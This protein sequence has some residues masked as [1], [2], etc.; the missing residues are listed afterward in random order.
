MGTT[1]HPDGIRLMTLCSRY[2]IPNLVIVSGLLLTTL[3]CA[4]T[5]HSPCVASPQSI[6]ARLGNA[7]NATAFFDLVAGMTERQRDSAILSELQSGNIPDFLRNL[8]PVS[9]ISRASDGTALSLTLCVMA[10]Y[11]SIGSDTDF[12]RMPMELN[13]ALLVAEQFGF[14]LP[15]PQ[16]VDLIYGQAPLH[17]APQP[18][19]AGNDMRSSEYY[20]LHNVMVKLQREASGMGLEVLTAGHKKDLVLSTRLWNMPGRVAIYGWQRPSG[21]PIQPLSTVHGSHYAD[22]SHGVRL[23]SNTVYVNGAARSMDDVIGDPKLAPLLSTEGPLPS[24]TAWLARIVN[25]TDGS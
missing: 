5:V 23:V 15:T 4:R 20:R 11:L 16:M 21:I 17:M 8:Q 14:T 13:T 6:P 12:S 1:N 22:Y 24:L 2:H 19:P 7:R 9:L 10:D 18:L 25:R 3:A